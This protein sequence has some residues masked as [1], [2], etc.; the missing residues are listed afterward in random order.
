[1]KS[2]ELIFSSLPAYIKDKYCSEKNPI[3]KLNKIL[4]REELWKSYDF[5]NNAYLSKVLTP[6]K[7][8]SYSRRIM[9]NRQILNALFPE[10]Y[11]EKKI[12]YISMSFM[13]NA[14]RITDDYI[15]F[16]KSILMDSIY[17]SLDGLEENHNKN[18]I[19]KSGKGSYQDVIQGI[20]KLQSNGIRVIPSVVITPDNYDLKQILEEF[21]NLG[22]DSLSFNLIRG[23]SKENAFSYKTMKEF[24]EIIKNIFSEI[25]ESVKKTGKSKKLLIL[26]NSILFSY[27][28][29]LYYGNYITKRCNWGENLV[30]DSKG[31]LYNCNSVIGIKKAKLGNYKSNKSKKTILYEIDVNRNKKCKRC[32]AKYLCGGTCYAEYYL[33]T[34]DNSNIECYFHKSLI[35]ENIFLYTKLKNENLLDYFMN[36]LK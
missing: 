21:I 7:Y 29:S 8:L 11:L 19:Y 6:S 10:F 18:R 1:M 34:T 32:Y 2:A 12:S 9:A 4:E 23:N 14:T 15:D 27:M 30:I 35:N 22:F 25:Y 16:L 24:I 13:T 26:K 20:K 17:V 33:K 36:E 3:I 5:S 31:D 28:K